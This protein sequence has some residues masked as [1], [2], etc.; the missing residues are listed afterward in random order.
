[1]SGI[2]RERNETERNGIQRLLLH[3]CD[4]SLL[5]RRI[6]EVER[7][8]RPLGKIILEGILKK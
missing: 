5:W 1:V 8:K 6:R 3:V 2:E 7:G 4:V